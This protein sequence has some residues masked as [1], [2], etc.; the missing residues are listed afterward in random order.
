M[1]IIAKEG[2]SIP[3]SVI[4]HGNGAVLREGACV[5]ALSRMIIVV[6]IAGLNV[7]HIWSGTKLVVACIVFVVEG[8]VARR[9]L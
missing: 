1:V 6:A 9:A 3:C 2:L 8:F 5:I 7:P 4:V